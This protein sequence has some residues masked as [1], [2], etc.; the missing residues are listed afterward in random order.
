MLYALASWYIR[1][2]GKTQRFTIEVDASGLG[3]LVCVILAGSSHCQ[4]DVAA[5][6]LL[7]QLDWVPARMNHLTTLLSYIDSAMTLDL[8]PVEIQFRYASLAQHN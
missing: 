6:L 3:H 7:R 8:H 1:Y 4:D 2:D 5:L